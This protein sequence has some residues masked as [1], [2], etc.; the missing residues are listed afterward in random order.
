MVVQISYGGTNFGY[1][2]GVG[3][4]QECEVKVTPPEKKVILNLSFTKGL[5]HP[6]GVS[7]VNGSGGFSFRVS[8]DY[9]L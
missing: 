7:V 3:L 4:T 5:N 6:S 8:N 9:W 2:E 1:R